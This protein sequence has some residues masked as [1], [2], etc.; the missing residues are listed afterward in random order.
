MLFL[1]IHLIRTI[2][3]FS[4]CHLVL[5]IWSM[6]LSVFMSKLIDG[7]M[8]NKSSEYIFINNA[9]PH[10]LSAYKHYPFD[11]DR[12]AACPV[13]RVLALGHTIQS[14][15]MSAVFHCVHLM[16]VPSSASCSRQWMLCTWLD[17]VFLTAWTHYILHGEQSNTLVL[18]SCSGTPN[19]TPHLGR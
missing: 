2:S 6:L 5:F 16:H 9:L 10:F 7:V 1:R 11:R 4:F 14:A 15:I 12:S 19:R 18:A 13:G 17:R 8:A 3:C